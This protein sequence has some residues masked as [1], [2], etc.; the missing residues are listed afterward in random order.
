MSRTGPLQG[1][2]VLEIQ[3]I[4]PGPFTAMVLA[5]LG[6]DVIRIDRPAPGGL[7]LDASGH[8]QDVLARSR[9]SVAVNLKA[10]AGVDVLLRLV[11]T[12]DVLIEGFRPGTAERLG[13]GPQ[14]CHKVNPGL[15]YGRM[16]GWGQDGP[17]AAMAGHDLNYIALAGALQPMGD[18]DKPPP[19]PLNLIGDFG[20]GGMLLVVG[21][22]AALHHRSQSGV[23]QVIDAA[24]VD[25]SALLMSMFHG[26]ASMG[27]WNTNTRAA[28]LLDGGAPFYDTY[29]CADGQFV[30]V[31]ALEPQFY[32][33]LLD[34]LGLDPDAWPQF[35][36]SR[37]DNLRV[38]LTTVFA[39]ADRDHWETVFSGSDACVAP[40]LSMT[41]AP[42]HPHLRQRGTFVDVDGV[43]QPAPA[44][45]FSATPTGPPTPAP[46]RGVHTLDVLAELG[47][48]AREIAELQE[49]GV[50][51]IGA[52][53]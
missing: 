52:A 15:I 24:M 53:D 50:I 10:A 48:D 12:A 30:A 1:L 8:G 6:A 16:T 20:G 46:S 36:L 40:V 11:G 42:E 22:L 35:D 19:V 32:A 28:N 25:G 31:G 26:M 51:V 3:G 21:I 23:G 33:A 43:V 27:V 47:L 34:G 41:Q 44:P 49:S 18:A 38:T 39:G 45:R 4:G 13:F 2:R 5:D 7:S 9:R 37:W 14:V 29:R 17:W